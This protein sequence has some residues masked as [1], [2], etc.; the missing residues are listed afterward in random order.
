[1]EFYASEIERDDGTSKSGAAADAGE[2]R[3]SRYV[4]VSW[5]KPGRQWVARI[6]HEGRQQHLGYFSEEE[7]AARAFDE[8]ARR[9]RGKK[10]K[11]HGGRASNRGV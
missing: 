9:L 8:A 1:M 6:Q 11:A 2:R 10:G 3:V 5:Y 7:A 4:G